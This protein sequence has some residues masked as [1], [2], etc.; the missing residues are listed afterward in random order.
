MHRRDFVL[1]PLCEVWPDW[2]H[3]LLGRMASEL[4]DELRQ[5]QR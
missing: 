2:R 5:A 4:L 3:P 1:A